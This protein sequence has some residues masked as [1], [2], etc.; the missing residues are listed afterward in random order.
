MSAGTHAQAH[1]RDVYSMAS[2]FLSC[3]SSLAYYADNGRSRWRFSTPPPKRQASPYHKPFCPRLPRE[4]V[5]KAMSKEPRAPLCIGE[6]MLTHLTEVRT[7]AFRANSWYGRPE[8]HCLGAYQ[9][10]AS[11]SSASADRASATRDRLI[12]GRR[13]GGRDRGQEDP[14][15]LRELADKVRTTPQPRELPSNVA[16]RGEGE[17]TPRRKPEE[18]PERD[19]PVWLMLLA[20]VFSG[21]SLSS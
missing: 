12:G 18:R 2:S 11:S 15:T 19:V 21:R 17:G 10:N 5:K 14:Q 3:S 4:V 6:E 9:A 7:P 20:H 16:I 1:D 13:F 8:T